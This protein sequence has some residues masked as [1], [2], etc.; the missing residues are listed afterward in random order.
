MIGMAPTKI[1]TPTEPTTNNKIDANES[2][3]NESNNNNNGTNNTTG[4][5]LGSPD[6]IEMGAMANEQATLQ[7]TNMQGQEM[8]QKGRGYRLTEDLGND[9]FD[10]FD[11]TKNDMFDLEENNVF[12]YGN[13]S[14]S[15]SNGS[16]DEIPSKLTIDDIPIYSKEN[17]NAIV[18][19]KTSNNT[20]NNTTNNNTNNRSEELKQN[21]AKASISLIRGSKKSSHI[22]SDNSN[23]KTTAIGNDSIN[24]NGKES[25]VKHQRA[26]HRI[27]KKKSTNI[28]QTTTIDQMQTS[29]I[30]ATTV[31]Q[32]KFIVKC[33]IKLAK[34]Q[35]KMSNFGYNSQ[36]EN[37]IDELREYLYFFVHKQSFQ[38]FILVCILVNLVCLSLRWHTMPT[39]LMLIVHIMDAAFL[40]IFL[41]ELF[42]KFL[43]F[44]FKN[45][46]K[47]AWNTLDGIIILVSCL[48]WII[49]TFWS[50]SL[51]WEKHG[52]GLA[53][54]ISLRLLRVIKIV[55]SI[56]WFENFNRIMSIISDVF[57][58]ILWMT[59]LLLVFFF[60]V[61]VKCFICHFLVCIVCLVLFCPVLPF[62]FHP[63]NVLML[64]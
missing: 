50:K 58:Q 56:K 3:A 7:V 46:W 53:A 39:V 54:I 8:R 14:S 52:S 60:M 62:V 45:Y 36:S 59:L 43:A 21:K 4:G 63:L 33:A 15:D 28:Q 41:I 17:I 37:R 11:E 57:T 2:K 12:T 19:K 16:G 23:N 42:L 48:V 55:R 5:A 22:T 35:S 24:N 20:N 34:N 32:D 9:I 44:G 26:K 64:S 13:A 31:K 38:I 47:S 51:N 49:L 27:R 61:G 40:F 1:I 30:S 6:A 18:K 29:L 10:D 25:Q